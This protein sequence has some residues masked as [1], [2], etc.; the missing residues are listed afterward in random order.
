M[1][2]QVPLNFKPL[3]PPSGKKIPPPDDDSETDEDDSILII[4]DEV[5]TLRATNDHQE[6]I[7]AI[8]YLSQKTVDTLAQDLRN[9][10]R[11]ASKIVLSYRLPDGIREELDVELPRDIY[12][13]NELTEPDVRLAML[14]A[15]GDM[16]INFVWFRLQIHVIHFLSEG[17]RNEILQMENYEDEDEKRK[18]RERALRRKE[19]LKKLE[20][21]KSSNHGNKKSSPVAAKNNP[22]SSSHPCI[23]SATS[24]LGTQGATSKKSKQPRKPKNPVKA[25]TS[26]KVGRPRKDNLS[27]NSSS[28][29]P[30][31]QTCSAKKQQTF[32]GA[33]SNG[34]NLQKQPVLVLT[35]SCDGPYK[36]TLVHADRDNNLETTSVSLQKHISESQTCTNKI[37]SSSITRNDEDSDSDLEVLYESFSKKS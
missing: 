5:G 9:N 17:A 20:T 30:V 19:N 25:T 7:R 29:S 34:N 37:S 8:R 33:K 12:T 28:T 14:D 15:L 26:R 3:G 1:N 36:S 10:Q 31:D 11:Y 23:P 16:P 21:L 35:R 32:L 22:S 6:L 18:K 13:W 27:S 24:A 4:K 2:Y